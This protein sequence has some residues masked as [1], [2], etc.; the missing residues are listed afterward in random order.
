M[1]EKHMFQMEFIEYELKGVPL[2]LSLGNRDLENDTLKCRRDTMEKEI[3][4][5]QHW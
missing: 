1:I 4:Q 5:I 3:Y 2:R